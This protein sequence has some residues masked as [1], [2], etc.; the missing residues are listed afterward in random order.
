[1][2]KNKPS[3]KPAGTV[4]TKDRGDPDPQDIN[5]LIGLFNEGR[6]E[7]AE[8]VASA[9]TVR[10]PRFGFGWKALG[11]LLCQTGRN[12][13]AV[14]PM[15]K[16]ATLSNDDPEIHFNLGNV[17][18]DLGHPKEAVASYRKALFIEPKYAEA[19]SNLGAVLQSQGHL[20]EAAASYL[21][22]VTLLPESAGAHFNL[23]N[24][25]ND[26]GR[27]DDAVGSYR[28]ALEIAPEY[29]EAHVNLGGVLQAQGR[30]EQALDSYR[31]AIASAPEFVDAHCRLGDLL[32]ALAHP[33]EAIASYHRALEFM[34]ESA[35]AHNGLGAALQDL[36]Q[37]E[38][39][40]A[41][42][43]QA[44]A[45]SPDFA[46]AHHNLGTALKSLGRLDEALPSLRRAIEIN[47]RIVE[48]HVNLGHVLHGLE[49]F[50]EAA[51]SFRTA[52][53]IAP[54][55]VVAHSNMGTALHALGRLEE[56]IGSYRRALVIDP[57]YAEAHLNLG[58]A[59]RDLGRPGD[60][61]ASYRRA[62]AAKP[63]H[64][65]ARSNL[66]FVLAYNSLVPAIDV[67]HEARQW[68]LNAI[69]GADRAAARLRD[70]ARKP[71]DSRR[72]K[73]GY[74]SGDY[75]QHPVSYFIEP[76]FREHDRSRVEL[77][78]YSNNK[79][80]DEVT[81]RL[82]ALADNWIPISGMSDEAVRQKV[83]ADGIDI[84]IDLSGYTGHHRLGVFALR[85]APVQSH[86]LG[87]FA[88][89][90]LTEMDYWL[91]DSV[92]LPA[93]EDEH[94]SETIWRLPRVWVSYQRRD[95]LAPSSWQPREDGTVWLG[96]FNNL[97]KITPAT[98][99][100]WAKILAQLP[101]GRLLLKAKGFGNPVYT[102]QIEDAMAAHGIAADR[103]ELLD[104]TDD[105]ASHMALYDRLDI[106]LDPVSGV[107]GGTTTSDAL[108]MGVP[109]VTLAG[110]QMIHRMSASM[111]DSIGHREWIA[112]SESEY[113]NKVVELA[114]DVELRRNLRS[115][116]RDKMRRSPL[117][118]A[119][120]LARSLEDA[121]EAMFD[122][123]WK[124]RSQVDLIG[125]VA[126]DDGQRQC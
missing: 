40:V 117:C 103:L 86:Y 3:N 105:W 13:E 29:A 53:E 91:G 17:L 59:Y 106:A 5:R 120:G 39:A 78:A 41:C 115:S 61:A 66:L 4:M 49:R 64:A 28:R 110:D 94:Y 31:R 92:I 102:K 30:L 101:E 7:E 11:V 93:A 56:A 96:S 104:K 32:K 1:M 48:A 63:E 50:A 52:L 72:L 15:R 90:G 112:E 44:L 107:G 77:F 37:L 25:L 100:L 69:S 109:V 27:F 45:I 38:E 114:R 74:V 10:F 33:D 9:M 111:L 76:L 67:L 16:A 119:A 65:Q 24:A 122:I 85:A 36:G 51:T 83:A 116:Q 26:L 14:V 18:K 21:R 42:H 12:A 34:P 82:K 87:Y 6:Y 97:Y 70:F 68:E 95:D 22:A 19:H 43:R 89:T 57:A 8:I 62:L 121:Y 118:D 47:P 73:I 79:T 23:G 126:A 98:L 84:L 75:R 60:A 99:A 2:S 55:N 20:D 80:E 35:E 54:Y 123:W 124:K 46:W 113:V 88:T 71:R 81:G 108:W 58:T 125:S